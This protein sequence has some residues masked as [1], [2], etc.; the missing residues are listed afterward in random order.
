MAPPDS[1]PEAPDA[2][3]PAPAAADASKYTWDQ[4]DAALPEPTAADR[5]AFDI[6]LP[7]AEL[8][9][10]G[11]K[12]SSTR[13]LTDTQRWLGQLVD[14]ERSVSNPGAVVL[15]YQPGLARVLAS[16][17]RKLRG[18]TSAQSLSASELKLRRTSA[19]KQ[20]DRVV[21]DTRL[22]YAAVLAPLLGASV[23]D[24]ALHDRVSQM[25]TRPGQSALAGQ[26]RL[27][28]TLLDAGSGDRP[29]CARRGPRA[30]GPPRPDLR[31]RGSSNGRLS[32]ART[33]PRRRTE[34]P[35]TSDPPWGA[36]PS[37][38]ARWP[39]TRLAAPAKGRCA[40]PG[41]PRGSTQALPRG[42]F[43]EVRV[44]A[45]SPRRER[46]TYP[47]RPWRCTTHCFPCSSQG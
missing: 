2:L 26:L 34:H 21:E 9:A 41:L 24:A 10:R 19:Q 3:R 20:L 11:A 4:L 35:S 13:L 23:G 1:P 5:A 25:P 32:S 22:R 12:I 45:P 33:R 30:P 8:Q 42:G 17:T 31:L 7:A 39:P 36:R 18:M 43:W 15:G 6:L 27:L 37:A 46:P 28:A 47:L 29:P 38:A 40:V 14:F 16:Y 44:A